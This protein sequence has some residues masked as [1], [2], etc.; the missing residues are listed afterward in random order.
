MLDVPALALSLSALALFLSGRSAI[1]GGVL[2]GLAMQTK[3]SALIVPLTIV[4]AGVL[5]SDRKTNLVRAAIAVFSATIVFASWELFVAAKYGQSHFLFHSAHQPDGWLRRDGLISPLIGLMGSVAA[6]LVILRLA[7]RDYSWKWLF[8]SA[9]VIIAG[10]ALIAIWPRQEG[11]LRTPTAVVFGLLGVAVAVA[12]LASLRD[13]ACSAIARFE[14]RFLIVWL[15]IE[16]IGYFA[17]TP[18]PAVRRV[19][20]VAV[21]STFVVAGSGQASLDM[22]KVWFAVCFNLGLALLYQG[23]EIENGQVERDAVAALEARFEF[24][25][26]Q[27]QVW[28]VGHRGWQ[29]YADREGWRHFDSH[30]TAELQAGDWLLVPDFEFTGRRVTLPSTAELV[31]YI[32]FWSRWRLGTIPWYYGTNAAVRRRDGPVLTV[33]VYRIH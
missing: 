22:R 28:F 14:S 10:L 29:H 15:A 2:A 21:A 32:E 26:S 8:L 24:H 5:S 27:S 16:V 9:G 25:K 17:L 33:R 30:R 19:I 18:W 3:Y 1:A 7:M 23:I 11:T 20:G 12:V 13:L 4:F 6:P 31:D